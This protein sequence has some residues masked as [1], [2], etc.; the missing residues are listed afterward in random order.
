MHGNP[1]LT[2]R[3]LAPTIM[4]PPRRRRANRQPAFSAIN[5]HE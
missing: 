5:E 3:F 4:R 2:G 1:A